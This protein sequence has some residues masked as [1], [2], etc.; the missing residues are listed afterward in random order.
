[1][2]IMGCLHLSLVCA[3]VLCLLFGDVKTQVRDSLTTSWVD[4]EALDEQLFRQQFPILRQHN[5]SLMVIF[6]N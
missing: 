6:L 3:A 2:C 5:L 1:M 4:A